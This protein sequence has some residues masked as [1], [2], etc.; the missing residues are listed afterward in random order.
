MWPSPA[1]SNYL[2]DVCTWLCHKSLNDLCNPHFLLQ[3]L[4]TL[5]YFTQNTMSV[6]PPGSGPGCLVLGSKP[7]GDSQKY[8]QAASQTSHCQPGRDSGHCNFE[9]S[10]TMSSYYLFGLI[11]SG[12][13]SYLVLWHS[14]QAFLWFLTQGP[15]WSLSSVPDS[16]IFGG[17]VARAHRQPIYLRAWSAS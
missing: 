15:S 8:L 1:V 7:L 11:A 17:L 14:C 13:P 6:A 4:L 12:N 3:W 2:L 5:Y 9:F 16:N 10:V